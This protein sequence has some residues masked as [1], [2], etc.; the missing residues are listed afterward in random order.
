MKVL[1]RAFRKLLPSYWSRLHARVL[2]TTQDILTAFETEKTK[3][4]SQT[5]AQSNSP[6]DSQGQLKLQAIYFRSQGN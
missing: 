5:P 4:K 2:R 1:A 3:G 6:G